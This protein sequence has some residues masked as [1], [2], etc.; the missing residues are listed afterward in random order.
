M[1]EIKKWQEIQGDKKYRINFYKNILNE[2]SIVFDLGGY[3][4]EWSNEIFEK[5]NTNIFIFEPIKKF[6]ENIVERFKTNQK[7]KIFQIGLSNKTENKTISLNKDSSSVFE[8]N[9]KHTEDIKLYDIVN[10]ID[11]NN[12]NII[13]LMKINVEG[14]E[15]YILMRLIESGY[16]TKIKHIQVQ[17]HEFIKNSHIMRNEIR[18][19]LS[20]THN[21]SYNFDFIWEGWE[22]KK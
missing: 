9:P 21:E 5:Y 1:K 15:Y 12:I 4:G 2:K 8:E 18:D 14:S 10:F 20:K 19:E 22:L 17:F 11:E 7:I 13:D 6:Y 16:I 3:R